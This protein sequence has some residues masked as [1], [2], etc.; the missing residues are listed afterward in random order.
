M[1][2]REGKTITVIR[3]AVRNGKLHAPF[4]S[5]DI[6]SLLGIRGGNFLAKHRVGNGYTTEHFIR[7][8]LVTFGQN[9]KRAGSLLRVRRRF[10][11]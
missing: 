7:V 2:T 6:N 11:C 4:R 5:A 3:A 8:G 1:L 10:V 9:H